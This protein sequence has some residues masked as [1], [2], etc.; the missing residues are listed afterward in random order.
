MEDKKEVITIEIDSKEKEAL[1]VEAKDCGL[2]LAGYC[3][4]TLLKSLKKM[5]GG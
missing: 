1:R 2:T 4:F 5:A 3:R